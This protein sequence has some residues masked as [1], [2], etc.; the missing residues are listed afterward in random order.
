MALPPA[1]RTTRS[2]C[3]EPPTASGSARG[4][5]SRPTSCSPR[6]TSCAKRPLRLA[7]RARHL[8]TTSARS[9]PRPRSRCSLAMTSRGPWSPAPSRA[10]WTTA[11]SGGVLARGTVRSR[12]RRRGTPAPVRRYVRG[13]F[14]EVRHGAL[15]RSFGVGRCSRRGGGVRLVGGCRV[16][17]PR[18][19]L[20]G[21]SPVRLGDLHH[22]RRLSGWALYEALFRSGRL[23][24]RVGLCDRLERHLPP[25][26]LG[27]IGLRLVWRRMDLQR[28]E[29]PG[30]ER[31]QG[32]ALLGAVTSQ[33]AH[34][35]AATRRSKKS[36]PARPSGLSFGCTSTGENVYF[37][38]PS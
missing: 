18:S 2:P 20:L 30:L 34:P 31:W 23:P 17:E 8:R 16:D 38:P 25:K 3:S 5:S 37:P 10:W 28:R 27:P 13:S 32:H 9:S 6:N 19:S 22:E 33:T 4:R 7:T 14:E 15:G 11:V 24:R 36:L 26:V 35:H 21:R 1:R 12:F 29:P